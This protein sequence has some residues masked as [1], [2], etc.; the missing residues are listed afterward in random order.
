MPFVTTCNTSDI[1]RTVEN[2]DFRQLRKAWKEE[3]PEFNRLKNLALALGVEEVIVSPDSPLNLQGRYIGAWSESEDSD[4]ARE[5][6][7]SEWKIRSLNRKSG[8]VVLVN[9]WSVF[10]HGACHTLAH[11][12]GHHIYWLAQFTAKQ[13]TKPVTETMRQ[14]FPFD[15]YVHQSREE[16]CA[17]SFAF[18]LTGPVEKNIVRYC[19]SVLRLVPKQ[20]QSE[21]RDFRKTIQ[22]VTVASSIPIRPLAYRKLGSGRATVLQGSA[23]HFAQLR[24]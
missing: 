15:T 6:G 7:L 18:Y 20:H 17:E 10:E 13:R 24:T 11:E 16:I 23:G 8:T 19:E 4:L 1:P 14:F 3:Q 12:I 5:S 2:D 22:T 9:S 21:I